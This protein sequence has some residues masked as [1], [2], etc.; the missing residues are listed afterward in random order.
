MSAK[1]RI[2]T[3]PFGVAAIAPAAGQQAAGDGRAA[4]REARSLRRKPRREWRWA[5]VGGL[6]Q[7]AV[8]VEVEDRR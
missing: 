4:E 6:L 7:R 3:S 2:A 8:G 1:L 5:V